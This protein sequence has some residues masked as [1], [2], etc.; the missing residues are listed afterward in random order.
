MLDNMCISLNYVCDGIQHCLDGT[1]EF[2]GCL[3][4]EKNC[5]GFLCNNRHCLTDKSWVCDGT[6]DCGDGSDEKNCG[7][8]TFNITS[9]RFCITNS[10]SFSVRLYNRQ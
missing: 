10:H 4:I 7:K 8:K 6:N 1:D 2:V 3:S 5:K 9:N